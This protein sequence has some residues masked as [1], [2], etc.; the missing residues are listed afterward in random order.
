MMPAPG[1]LTH[2]VLAGSLTGLPA[3]IPCQAPSLPPTALQGVHALSGAWAGD[4]L[5]A[6]VP[7][8]QPDHYIAGSQHSI[9]Q[10][11][12]QGKGGAASV[13]TA[14]TSQPTA[15]KGLGH[16]GMPPQP[17]GQAATSL[18]SKVPA[19]RQ[20]VQRDEWIVSDDEGEEQQQELAAGGYGPQ[21]EM[22][23]LLEMG[24]T[25]KQAAKVQALPLPTVSE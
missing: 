22:A 2:P 8:F 4:S 6:L 11:V 20:K 21:L 3:P 25:P 18:D 1:P 9:S 24:F 16:P 5:A 19:G 23:Q 15:Q 10:P 7:R 12:R 17:T 13:H 14:K